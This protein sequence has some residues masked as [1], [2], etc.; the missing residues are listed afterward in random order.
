MVLL[1]YFPLA[2][3]KRR[4]SRLH[5]EAH[6]AKAR[7]SC[8]DGL[9]GFDRRLHP[10]RHLRL[11][12]P[13]PIRRSPSSNVT[14]L[15]IKQGTLTSIP[16]PPII[17]LAVFTILAQSRRW[18][19]TLAVVALCLLGMLF[20]FATLEEVQPNPYVPLAVQVVAIVVYGI[21]SLLLVSS[22]V[23]GSDRQGTAAAASLR[24]ALSTFL[25]SNLAFCRLFTEV[26][27]REALGS[28]ACRRSHILARTGAGFGR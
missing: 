2:C 10:G 11:A 4:K 28:F 1:T 12:G 16:L 6:Y 5:G 7:F 18:W 13:G 19:G 25:L 26:S 17:A 9:G 27:G 3:S 14:P 8:R 20:I 15:D 22:D 24:R 21:L 23:V